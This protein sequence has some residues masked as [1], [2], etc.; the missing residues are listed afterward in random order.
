SVFRNEYVE[1][2]TT[3]SLNCTNIKI[4]WQDLIFVLWRISLRD[5]NC[6]IAMAKNDSDY[7]SCQ[8]GK[9]LNRTADGV[10]HLIIPQ[11]SLR[12]EGNYNCDISYKSGGWLE[13][14]TVF[15]FA[16]PIIS[17]WLENEDQH[18]VAVCEAK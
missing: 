5:K 16:R 17:G 7:D 6:S 10:Y 9:R 8:D 15:G 3:V 12:D 14:I 18:V 1:L 2:G 13:N 4:A 11:F